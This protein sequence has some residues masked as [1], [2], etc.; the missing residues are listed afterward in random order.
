MRIHHPRLL[1]S[2]T[3][4]I[5]GCVLVAF[6]L[7]T[8]STVFAQDDQQP[9]PPPTP[10]PA[11]TAI[12]ASQIPART[13][14][15][16]ALLRGIESHA[17]PQDEITEMGDLLTPTSETIDALETEVLALL[18]DD[19]PAQELKDVDV[20]LARVEQRLV[21]W[22]DTLH[23]RT[24][25]L[26]GDL[27][28][29]RQRKGQWELTRD[30]ADS[31]ELPEAL[32]TGVQ[33]TITTIRRTEKAIG[34]RRAD[35]LTIQAGMAEQWS[36][37]SALREQ[38]GEEVELRQLDLLRL[39][40][41]PLWKAFG[42]SPDEDMGEQVLAAAKKNLEVFESF[43]R[44][45]SRAFVR[46]G[47][48]FFITLILFVRFGR[49]AQLW[50]RSDE[51]LRTTAA[52]LER[53]VA[54]SLLI[55]IM[56]GG[57]WFQPTAPAAY[58]NLVGLVLLLITLRLLPFLV[59][60]ELRPAIGMFVGLVAG[61]LV[62]DL[63][64]SVFVLHRMCELLLAVLGAAT[65]G[66]LLY[67]DRSVVR[68]EKNLWY[69]CAFWL[70]RIA[71]VVFSI[72]AVAN[73]AG[74]VA[75]SSIL[76][77]ATLGSIYDAITL[78]MFAVVLFGAVTIVLRTTTARRLLIVR[79][80]SDR[81][82]M[83]VF[84]LIKVI[85]VLA[86]SAATLDYYGALEWTTR[87]IKEFLLFEYT[88]GDFSFSVSGF[89]IFIVVIWLSVKLAQ[90]ISFVLDEDVLP[91]LDLPKGV[92]ATISKTSTYLVVTIGSVI[93]V[94]AAGLDVSRATL[95]VGALGVGIGF[96][97]QNAVNNFVSGLIL[98]FGRPINVGDKI[99]IGEI[100][101]RVKDIGIRATVVQTWQGA[102]VI[103][104]NATLISDNLIN[105]TLSDDRRRMDIPIGVAYG[106]STAQV[107]EVLTD[108]A[109]AHKE[110]LRD[111]EPVAIFTGFGDSALDFELRA[112]TR[113]GHVTV[114]SDLRLGIDRVLAEHGIEIPFPQRDLHLRTVDGKTPLIPDDTTETPARD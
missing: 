35:V 8:A 51:T 69:W 79:Y 101:G 12:P 93:A 41:P 21:G 44:E 72:S 50:V 1:E 48:V 73:I 74:A 70:A 77:S 54:S 67:R 92:P 6:V 66:W 3:R 61:Y 59:R 91:R 53:P 81:I 55:T 105:W 56:V 47:V 62:V 89:G 106:S 98:L 5:M 108:V 36:R 28:D 24:V 39:D 113:G 87:T 43:I 68:T 45:N 103:V 94:V 27:E 15:V 19:G 80:H 30:E 40:S 84:R 86:W 52:V 25:G 65:A 60:P 114:A 31:D 17:Q 13:G 32:V 78:W 38:V 7:A 10:V 95:L 71:V 88:L 33:A 110:V 23:D 9:A 76:V 49:K 63:I 82:R 29:L 20:D 83:V 90:F 26:D 42:D 112:W 97:L 104:P 34:D 2:L 107:I 37:L 16:A 99:Q 18:E 4:G 100:S 111:P 102:E 85:A 96:G 75:L 22:L 46:N 11:P 64:P 14:E 58:F 57:G 109:R